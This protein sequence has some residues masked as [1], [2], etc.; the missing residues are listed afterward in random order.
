[1]LGKR[2]DVG[3]DVRCWGRCRLSVWKDI[4]QVGGEGVGEEVGVLACMMRCTPQ[5]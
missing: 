2:I 4:V 3:E 1:M 5:L